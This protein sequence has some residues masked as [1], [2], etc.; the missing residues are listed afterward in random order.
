MTNRLRIAGFQRNVLGQGIGHVKGLLVAKNFRA[1]EFAMDSGV[2]SW[3]AV[4][5]R[6]VVIGQSKG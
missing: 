4:R 6:R 1:D 2:T 5:R 3:Q